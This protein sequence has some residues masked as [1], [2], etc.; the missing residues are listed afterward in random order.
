MM[1]Q[2][3]FHIPL[4]VK[5]LIMTFIPDNKCDSCKKIGQEN[6]NICTCCTKNICNKCYDENITQ[7]IYFIQKIFTITMMSQVPFHIPLDVKK[8]IMTCI[9]DNKCDSCNKIGQRK[10]IHLYVLY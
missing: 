1:S 2:V 8:L 6:I 4:D 5:K 10:N 7:S 9:P 3:L